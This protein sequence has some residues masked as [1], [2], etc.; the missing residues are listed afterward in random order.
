MSTVRENIGRS[1]AVALLAKARALGDSI[2]LSHRG[3]TAIT[4]FV[5]VKKEPTSASYVD[6][7]GIESEQRECELD[8]PTGQTSFA[9][10]TT[11]AEPLECGDIFTWRGRAWSIQSHSALQFGFVHRV[12]AVESKALRQ[13]P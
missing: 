10:S 4:L 13:G 1:I 5:S 7:G 3:A 12:K 2:S 11:E 8:I 6:A 9:Y